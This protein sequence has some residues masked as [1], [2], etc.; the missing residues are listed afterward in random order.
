MATNEAANQKPLWLSIEEKLAQLD[1]QDLSGSNLEAAIH[2]VA[3]ELDD[4]GYNVSHHGGRLI[5]LR[6]AVKDMRGVGRPLMKDINEA[7]SALKLEDLSEPYRVTD[8][9]IN[10]IGQSW[11]QL[12]KADRRVEVIRMVEDTKLALLIA[13]AKELPEDQSIRLLLTEKVAENVIIDGLGITRE[14]LDQVKAEIKKELAERD[15]VAT[16]LT[17]VEGKSDD[18]RIKHLFA[19]DVSETLIVEMAKVDQAAIEAVKQALEAELKEKQRLE[20]EA[21]AKRKAE[22]AGPPI[23][24]IPPD[25]MLEYIESIREILEFSD[26]E[27][28]I[29]VMCEQSSIPKALVDI[30]VSDPD[31]L[32]ELEKAAEG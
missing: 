28:E 1:A 22:A 3:G 16:L 17:A 7:I 15:R 8:T 13:K 5:D 30:A 18:D 26:Q 4:A 12:K 11:P 31:K 29:R 24:A 27:K 2:R 19:N 14:K 25:K 6:L 21:A 10:E 20:E 32:D 23:E 9:L